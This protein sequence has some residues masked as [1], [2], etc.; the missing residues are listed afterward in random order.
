MTTFNPPGF[1]A[2][3]P[4]LAKQGWD[5]SERV[6][7]YYEAIPEICLDAWSIAYY[8]YKPPFDGPHWTDFR[9]NRTPACWW[10]LPVRQVGESVQNWT[11]NMSRFNYL[12]SIIEAMCALWPSSKDS[13]ED[14]E[15]LC[16]ITEHKLNSV[17]AVEY[18]SFAEPCKAICCKAFWDMVVHRYPSGSV[19]GV[20]A[21]FDAALNPLRDAKKVC[22][23]VIPAK[24]V[25][26]VQLNLDA[27]AKIV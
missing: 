7:V 8:H 20:E 6:L 2:D 1:P 13:A 10:P 12:T 19:C 26:R 25:M 9:Y 16:K 22:L 5:H 23:Y 27:D 17:W 21:I 24:R 18:A 3:Q 11:P 15:T 4:P 14:V